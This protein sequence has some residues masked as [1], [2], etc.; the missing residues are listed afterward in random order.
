MLYVL[1][2]AGAS[3]YGSGK[4]INLQFSKS[5]S[6]YEGGPYL[7]QPGDEWNQINAGDLDF[8]A[9]YTSKPTASSTAMSRSSIAFD[10]IC[11]RKVF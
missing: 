9:G 4:L 5:N 3:A 1:F 11:L 2:W 7:R 8:N 6:P 10:S